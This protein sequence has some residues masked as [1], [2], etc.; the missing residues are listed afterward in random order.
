MSGAR[1]ISGAWLEKYG[2]KGGSHKLRWEEEVGM[3]VGLKM[4]TVCRFS[5][6]F[7]K[8]NSSQMSTEIG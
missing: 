8:G 2:D 4:S 5:F 1:F 7:S 3:K 6:Y